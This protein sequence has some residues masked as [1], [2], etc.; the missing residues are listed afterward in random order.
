MQRMMLVVILC[1]VLSV[2]MLSANDVT[3]RVPLSSEEIAVVTFDQ[4]RVSQEGVKRWM[5]LDEHG[6]YS[7]PVGQSY[8]NCKAVN[9]PKLEQDVKN[10]RQIVDDLDATKYPPELSDVVAYLKRVQSFWLW[11]SEQELEFVKNGRLPENGYNG[12]DLNSCTITT[13]SQ[14]DACRQV[15]VGWHNCVLNASRAQLGKYPKQQWKAFLDAY[16]IQERL[17]STIDD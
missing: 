1:L 15:L 3:I 17:E 9:I 7:A 12:I 10:G 16:G 8:S 5:Q 6:Y 4:S 2:S 13:Q 11:Q 14:A